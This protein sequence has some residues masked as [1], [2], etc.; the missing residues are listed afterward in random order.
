VAYA[1]LKAERVPTD[2]R[3]MRLFRR[4]RGSSLLVRFGVLGLL[5]TVGVGLVLAS[6]LSATI[7]DRAQ[8]QAEGT[9]IGT[10]RLGLQPQIT[11]ADLVNGFDASRLAVVDR[12]IDQAADNLLDGEDLDDLDPVALKIF[13]RDGT[14][15]WADDETLIGQRSSSPELREALAGDVVSGFTHTHDDSRASDDGDKRMLE[16]YVPIQYQGWSAPSGVMELYLPY[17]PVA[18]AVAADVRT[19]VIA[20]VA[21]L[22]VFYACLVRFVAAADRRLRRQTEALQESADRNRHQATHDALT[23]LPNRVLLRDRV[24]QALAAA[25]RGAAEVAVLMIDLDRFKE[26]NDSLGHSYGDELL[27][28]VGPRLESVLREGDTVARLGGDEFAVLLPVVDG[29]GEAEAVAERLR[30][31]LHRRFEVQGVAVDLEASVGIAVSPWHGTDVEDLLRNADIAMYV[32]KEVKAGAVLFAPEEHSTG[33]TQLTVLGDLRTALDSGDELFLHYQPKVTLDGE[34]IEGLEAL[35]RWQH[36]ERGLIPP[37]DFIPVAEGTG[38]IIRLTERVLGMALEAMR[39]WRDRGVAVPVA[40]NLSAR[41]LL[42][43]SLP[44]LVARLLRE[45]DVPAALLRLEVT[46]S[47]VMTD[48]ARCMDVLQRLHELGVRLSID[49]FGTGYSSMVHLRRLPV[50][51]LKIDRSFVLGM[52]TMTAD[53]VLVRSAIDLG[54]NLGLTVVA[55]GVEGLE[56]VDALRDLGCDVAQGYHYARPMGEADV[57]ALL[58]RSVRVPDPLTPLG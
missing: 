24:E 20:L 15:V 2:G 35:L 34:A 42:D 3:S 53:A 27:C 55:E 21:S 5:L 16:V 49:D 14:I 38:I 23:G 11:P 7:E 44:D 13:N 22:A 8:E 28:Q 40:V 4:L 26:I 6:V 50:D 56:H 47:A 41:C 29:V 1:L 43:S 39:G 52:T 51:E 25:S 46:E 18:A 32:A 10:V 12:A 19:L 57:T 45:N 33:R 58:E 17:G 54:H 48:A 30:E 9:V 37:S 31:A 36:P